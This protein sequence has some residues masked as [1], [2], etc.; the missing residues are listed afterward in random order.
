M[1][2]MAKYDFDDLCRLFPTNLSGIK[3]FEITVSFVHNDKSGNYQLYGD[4][5]RCHRTCFVA[6]Q[7]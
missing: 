5:S 7:I 2:F 1:R 4:N 6:K 3:F